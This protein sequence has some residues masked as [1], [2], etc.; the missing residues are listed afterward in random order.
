MK[1]KNLKCENALE[2]IEKNSDKDGGKRQPSCSASLFIRGC[3]F[4]VLPLLRVLLSSLYPSFFFFIY[5]YMYIYMI[6]SVFRSL[7]KS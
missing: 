4:P 2:W 7:S 5:I 6:S 3:P 1:N